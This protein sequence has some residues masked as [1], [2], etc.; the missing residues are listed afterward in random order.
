VPIDP[1]RLTIRIGGVELLRRGTARPE[2][3]ERARAAMKAAEFSVRI[4][5]G[6]G[7]GAASL[8][9]TDLSHDYVELNSVYST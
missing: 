8:I 1:R 7:S 9:T 2:N 6:K 5:L 4:D 3:A